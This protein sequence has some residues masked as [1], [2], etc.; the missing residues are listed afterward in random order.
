MKQRQGG[1][2]LIELMIV[3][4]IIG[5]LAAIALPQYENYTIRGQSSEGLALA[6]G[7][8]TNVAEIFAEE[9][10]LAGINSGADGIPAAATVNG[11][12][13]TGVAVAAGVITVTFGNDA[14][15]NLAG[16]N[17][18]LTPVDNGGSLEWGCTSPLNAT[19]PQYLPAACR[20]SAP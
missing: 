1:F 18:V 2:T 14:N 4:A 3:I 16:A 20:N 19:D 7:L 6:S 13:V 5:I 8:K 11:N 17:M 12:Y 15:A 10:A 9:G